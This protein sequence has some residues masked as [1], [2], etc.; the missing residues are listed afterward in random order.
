MSGGPFHKGYSLVITDRTRLTQYL[1]SI[2][3]AGFEGIEPTFV[4]GAYPSPEDHLGRARELRAVCDDLGLVIPSMRGGLVPWA[5]I[6][7]DDSA[8]RARAL[9]HTRR[10]LESLAE[11][12]GK[13]LLVVPGERMAGVDYQTHWKRVVEF[14]HA[15]GELAR[16]FGIRI[17]FEN[18]E[19]RFP[20]SELEWCSLIDETGSEHIGMYLD[21]GNVVWLGFGYPEQW[22]RTLGPR[23]VQVHFKDAVYRLLGAT[24]HA[25]VRQVLDGEVN[26]PAVM[27]A[28][29]DVSYAGWISV[30]PE[31]YRHFS[32]VL[33]GHL[34]RALDAII[35]HQWEDDGDE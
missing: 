5:T 7:S 24:L 10:A 21:V 14:G 6:P 16:G 13:V 25:E 35:G 9:E 4:S 34:S 19:A 3:A 20:V 15:A 26:W 8:E 12:G 18:V 32:E 33:P 31:G 1:P 28:L 27:A 30:E 17:G 23:I 29:R 2:A 11:M 22:I